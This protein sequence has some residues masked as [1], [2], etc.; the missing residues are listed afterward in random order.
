MTPASLDLTGQRIAVTGAS[1]G[2][3][4]ALAL[5]CAEAGAD[6]AL[7]ART[8]PD[9]ESLALEIKAFGRRAFILP[10]DVSD[11]REVDWA[12]GMIADGWGGL[13]GLVNNA[14][15]NIR[16]PLVEATDDDWSKVLHTNLDSAFYCCRAAARL[17]K[18]GG[19]GGRIVLMSSVAGLV[20]V[21]TGVAYAATKAALNQ[22]A[23]TLALELG[24]AQIRV[25]AV[26]PWYI[27]TPLTEGLLDKPEYVERILRVTPLGR[28]GEPVDLA[29]PVLF[30]LSN[31]SSYVT[32]QTLAVDGGMTVVGMP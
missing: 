22:M 1:R 16:K 11:A 12:F 27:R 15:I 32:G 20:A 21:P 7:L 18:N 28:I 29:G 6:V 31:A 26:A 14:G 30:L 13:D 5:V 24:P 8:E 9:L 25:N 17:M 10:T 2:I 19:S 3:G 23:R 4:R